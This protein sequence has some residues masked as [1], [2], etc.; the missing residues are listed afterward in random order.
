M[1]IKIWNKIF[2]DNIIDVDSI[3]E[4]AWKKKSIYPIPIFKN[5]CDLETNFIKF[6]Q[7]FPESENEIVDAEHFIYSW[8]DRFLYDDCDGAKDFI[9]TKWFAG[10][11]KGNY[12]FIY[13]IEYSENEYPFLHVDKIEEIK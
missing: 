3:L 1:K 5:A 7:I 2:S 6:V 8:M 12:N 9:F 11:D 13:H 10:L 4:K